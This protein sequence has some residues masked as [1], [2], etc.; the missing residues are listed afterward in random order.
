[1]KRFQVFVCQVVEWWMAP[2]WAVDECL[3]DWL[4]NLFSFLIFFVS[5]FLF[6]FIT[7]IFLS[8]L[9]QIVLTAITIAF[10]VILAIVFTNV[11]PESYVAT[12]LVL[13]TLT[14]FLV[15]LWT[16]SVCSLL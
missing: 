1:M 12:G 9:G 7:S 16:I 4:P 13:A 15:G 11:V 5:Y 14:V 8:V 10:G 6:G 3:P 2:A